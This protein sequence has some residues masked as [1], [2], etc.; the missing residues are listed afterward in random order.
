MC[1]VGQFVWELFYIYSLVMVTGWHGGVLPR[2]AWQSGT[3]HPADTEYKT[4]SFSCHCPQAHVNTFFFLFFF[5]A[6]S[7]LHLSLVLFLTSHSSCFCLF[8]LGIAMFAQNTHVQQ[9]PDENMI[10]METVAMMAPTANSPLSHYWWIDCCVIEPLT[11]W[12]F[13]GESFS[14][15]ILHRGH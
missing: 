2:I 4:S 11:N 6:L 3:Q 10:R 5:S 14:I 15:N 9:K 13:Y 1:S 12:F 7:K 8:N